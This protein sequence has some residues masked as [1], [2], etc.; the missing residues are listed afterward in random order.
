MN[1]HNF[2]VDEERMAMLRKLASVQDVSVSDLVREAIDLVIA[3]RMNNPRPSPSDRRAK[4][5]A[6]LGGYAGAEPER[7][8]AVDEAIVVA[9][10]AE[11]KAR[12]KP[13][14]SAR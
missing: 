5:D 13:K 6:F 7:D 9:V 3:D 8:Q 2:Y 4:F 12:R 14:V 1:R 10:A 11:R